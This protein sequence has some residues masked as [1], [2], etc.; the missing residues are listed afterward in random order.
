MKI[1][2]A[3]T[4]LTG[5]VNPM[6]AIGRAAAARGDDVLVLTDPAFQAK[7]E[8]AGLRFTPYADNESAGYLETELPAGPE[9][10]R[11]EFQRRF[12]D[13]MPVQTAALK[14]LIAADAPDVI[15][16]G[17]MFLGVLPLLLDTAPRPPIVT[18]N[19]SILFLDRPDH[20]PVGLGL[21]PARDQAELARYAALKV[22]MDA[23]FANPV[24]AYAD[25][26]LARLGVSRC[27]PR[28]RTP[29]S[30][31][32]TCSCSRP[33]RASSTITERCLRA[34]ASSACCSRLP[35]RPP[36]RIGGRNWSGPTRRASPW[37]WSPR[38]PS[39]TRISAL[40]RAGAR[41]PRRPD[42]LL[43]LATTGGRPV[44]ACAGRSGEHAGRALPAVPRVAAAG[45]R[46]RHQWRAM[47]AS[48]S[49]CRTACRSSRRPDRGQ[50]GGECPHRLVGRRHQSRHQHAERGRPARGGDAGARRAELPAA[51]R[52]PAG[53]LRGARTR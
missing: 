30:C 51:G 38:A 34:C 52:N 15:V 1:L 35:R 28:C 32:P 8:E 33:C 42:D 47:A 44:E 53:R 12:I 49:R 45:E 50:G 21:P 26:Q 14:A 5:H 20:A 23:A 3:A 6:L 29:S 41:R 46:A 39:P 9:R 37:S 7:V 17:S 19:I 18:A 48:R 27:R 40:G 43:V 22:G 2:I 10:F 25:A 13:P 16:A 31:C 11:H 4:P 24:R 36:C